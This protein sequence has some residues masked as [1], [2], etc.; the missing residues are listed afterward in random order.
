MA[1]PGRPE[2]EYPFKIIIPAKYVPSIR[3]GSL[4]YPGKRETLKKHREGSSVVFE[5]FADELEL[6]DSRR[7]YTGQGEWEM[8]FGKFTAPGIEEADDITRSVGVARYISNS[9]G[10]H[11]DL[12]R[13]IIVGESENPGKNGDQFQSDLRAITKDLIERPFLARL[14][15]SRGGR[16]AA[17]Y[18]GVSLITGVL[19]E[20]LVLGA[21][22]LSGADKEVIDQVLLSKAAIGFFGGL[23]LSAGV[24]PTAL[25]S[26]RIMKYR[27][28]SIKTNI[29]SLGE[30]FADEDAENKLT[31]L[32]GFAGE[33]RVMREAFQGLGEEPDDFR[34]LYSWLR[35]SKGGFELL[36]KRRLEL[37]TVIS[38]PEKTDTSDNIL[39]ALRGLAGSDMVIRTGLIMPSAGSS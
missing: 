9:Q 27:K 3:E 38:E 26:N 25:I 29:P 14:I 6:K 28:K 36:E 5:P 17:V 24:L 2:A 35:K 11:Y 10:Q 22:Y 34:R 21:T 18:P 4:Y 13:H 8:R 39:Q 16:F 19:A 30:Y 1:S 31:E 20:G 32:V 33:R 23:G 7:F 12:N 15:D 37:P